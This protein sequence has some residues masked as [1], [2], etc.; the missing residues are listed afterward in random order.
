MNELI[1]NLQGFSWYIFAFIVLLGVVITVH[2]WGHFAVARRCGVKVLRFSIGFG[3]PLWQ[4]TG[5]DGTEYVVALLPLGGYVKMLDER[6]GEVAPDE[7]HRAF[8]R[9]PVAQRFAIVAA[10]PLINLLLA[11]VL[12]WLLFVV[13]VTKMAPVIGH[14]EAESPAALAGLAVGDRVLAIDGHAIR[15]WDDLPLRIVARVG[16]TGSIK[17]QVRSDFAGIERTVAL[18]VTAFMHG[19]EDSNPLAVLGLRPWLPAQPVDIGKVLPIVTLAG[20]E[21]PGP[22]FQAGLQAGD[23]VLRADGRT[24]TSWGDW[25]DAVRAA[26]GRPLALDVQRGDR[27][28]TLT[29]TPAAQTEGARTVGFVGAGP[30]G[31]PLRFPGD[32]PAEYL[33]E[34]RDGPFAAAG[35]ALASTWDRSVLTVTMIGKLIT[36]EL[37]TKSIGGP[38]TIARG[39]GVTMSIGLEAFVDFL[40]LVSITI[41]ILNLLPLPVLDGGHL[42]FYAVEAVRGRPLSERIQIA[43]T[44]VGV[45][46]LFALMAL[47]IFNDVMREFG[48]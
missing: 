4:R 3:K 46:L 11:V 42:V 24:L 9:K 33:V 20:L 5:A 34:V 48:R 19:R 39:A 29:I 2:E 28:V 18:P 44:Q 32:W 26:P 10:G 12:Y 1:A 43:A 13:G 15:S 37:S 14:V 27:V 45:A 31:E 16:D 30:G 22:A 36:G 25:V 7:L 41:G 17:L 38:I 23:R 6:E 35:S 8:N 47:A 21:Q 40:A